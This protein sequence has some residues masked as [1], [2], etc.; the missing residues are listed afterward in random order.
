M[1]V[2]RKPDKFV[3]A[4]FRTDKNVDKWRPKRSFEPFFP[5]RSILIP[6][7]S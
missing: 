5:S 1:R 7:F 2:G 4:L 6:P 3:A